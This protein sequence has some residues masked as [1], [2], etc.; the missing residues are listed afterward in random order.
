MRKIIFINFF[1]ILVGYYAHK[2]NVLKRLEYNRGLILENIK[3]TLIKFW[4]G[5]N[6]D[7]TEFWALK[8]IFGFYIIIIILFR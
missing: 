5:F 2:I 8:I 6:D 1:R 7:E 3:R 4:F